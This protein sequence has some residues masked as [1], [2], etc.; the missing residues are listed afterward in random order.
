MK[1]EPAAMCGTVRFAPIELVT[2]FV[3]EMHARMLRYELDLT[4]ACTRLLACLATAHSS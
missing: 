4:L 3:P 1:E 2:R